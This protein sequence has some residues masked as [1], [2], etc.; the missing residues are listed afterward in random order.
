MTMMPADSELYDQ[1]ETVDVEK[2]DEDELVFSKDEHSFQASFFN[3]RF[4]NEEARRQA[5]EML[6]KARRVEVEIDPQSSRD[7]P[8]D[9]YVFTDGT[10][11]QK[12]LLEKGLA[13]INIR[14]PEYIHEA[15]M[16]EGVAET[17]AVVADAQVF[18]DHREVD[19]FYL[20]CLLLLICVLRKGFKKI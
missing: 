19:L 11:L 15:E 9:V 14:N 18:V 13:L 10:L 7:Q 20:P 16:E 17:T 1:K 5:C 8:V 6:T 2:C 12:T 3:I 4:V